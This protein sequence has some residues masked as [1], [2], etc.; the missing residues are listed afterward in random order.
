MKANTDVHEIIQRHTGA[1]ESLAMRVT[2]VAGIVLAIALFAV[3]MV[4]RGAQ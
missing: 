1:P 2:I 4:L 3:T